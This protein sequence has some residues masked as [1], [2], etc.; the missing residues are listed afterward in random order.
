[1][2]IQSVYQQFVNM[3]ILVYECYNVPCIFTIYKI[4]L[5]RNVFSELSDVFILLLLKYTNDI[6]RNYRGSMFIN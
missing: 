4:S 6:E 2:Y 5:P 3:Y 1:V